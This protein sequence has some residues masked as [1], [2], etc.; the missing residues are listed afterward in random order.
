MPEPGADGGAGRRAA[1]R[2]ARG[3]G[4]GALPVRGAR[5]ARLRGR[6]RV[7]PRL[8]RR[9]LRRRGPPGRRRERGVPQRRARPVGEPR[10]HEPPRRRSTSATRPRTRSPP[11][12]EAQRGHR[13]LPRRAGDPGDVRAPDRDLPL[14]RRRLRDH[15]RQRRQPRR[16]ARGARRARR[17]GPA[18]GRRQPHAE[19]RLPE[20]VHER[21]A[22]R[23]R[24]RRDPAR[25]RPAGSARADR[26][27]PREVARG[28]GR[29][30][31]G[32]R[33]P[34]HDAARC[35]SPT[36]RSIACSGRRR[37]SRSPSTPAT[38]PCSTGAWSTP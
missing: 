7:G 18:R 28:L 34:R 31:R 27:V 20:R 22:H 19:L 21:H 9:P 23:D 17:V 13:L 15:L 25:R 33:A 1:K 35:G 30:L 16:R 12:E 4:R 26:R 3:H 36:R 5:L 10:S 8:P 37:T 38:S 2:P 11:D 24:R 32:P 6:R 14:D 29:R